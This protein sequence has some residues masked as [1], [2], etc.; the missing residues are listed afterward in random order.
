MDKDAMEALATLL[1]QGNTTLINNA[2]D[3]TT[4][5]FND[6]NILFFRG[7]NYVPRNDKLRWQIVELFHDHE[8]A[9]HPGELE[10]FNAIQQCYWWP[11]LRTFVK[12]YVKECGVCQQ[13]KIDRN[14]SKPAFLPVEGA[15]S[16]WPFANCSMDL[17]TD[18]PLSEGFDS[19]LVVVDQGL[20]KGVILIPCN[21]TITV[22]GTAQLLFK[23]LYKRFGLPD[24]IIS[25]RGPQFTSK[26]FI[27]L[28]KLLGIKSA[29]STVYHP[30]TDGATEWVNQ[31]IEA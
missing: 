29:L 8:T 30:Q 18:L 5:K 23:N 24:K 16:T 19:L 3:W 17:I 20:T 10:T 25:D 6:K 9:G 31:E 27:E 13:F 7:K 26:A 1:N 12:N 14:L 22:E 4:E 2:K 28:S 15:I 11:G 21:R